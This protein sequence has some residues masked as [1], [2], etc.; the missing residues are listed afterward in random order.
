MAVALEYHAECRG[1]GAKKDVVR[2]VVEK[3]ER[4]GR[5]ARVHGDRFGDAAAK[6]ARVDV[7][8]P[9]AIA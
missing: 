3:D 9:E 1:A 7:A 5:R 2:A 6:N 8:L 4:G